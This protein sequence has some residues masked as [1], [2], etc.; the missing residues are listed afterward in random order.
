[1]FGGRGIEKKES[2]MA[3]ILRIATFLIIFIVGI[4]IIVMLRRLQIPARVRRAEELFGENEI[5]RASEI[6][7]LVL[8]KKKDYVPARYL[9]AK[10]LMAQKQFL[11]AIS[12]LNSILQMPDVKKF[13]S[14]SE[15]HYHLAD[16]YNQTQQ[17]QKEIEEYKIILTFNSGDVRANY[18]VGH[19]LYRNHKY[20]EVKEHL[21]IAM[22]GDPSLSDCLLPLGVSSYHIG[23]YDDAESFLLKALENNPNLAE[24][25]YYLGLIF[26]KKTDHETAIRMFENARRD[27]RF[28]LKSLH[29]LGEIYFENG[30]YDK[31][32]E[33]LEQGIG[34][35]KSDDEESLSFRY[36]LAESYEV[37]NRI[38][39]A[40]YHW[41][42]ISKK[43][44]DYRDVRIKMDD[45]HRIL[46]NENMKLVFSQS[47]DELQPLLVEIISS[48]NYNIISKNAETKDE[49][50]FKAF[51]IKRINEPPILV[52][53]NRTVKEITENQILEFHK[54]IIREKS[55]SGIY[56]TTSK[57]SLRAKS[58]ATTR[59]I[60]LLDSSYLHKVIEKIRAK[61]Q[62]K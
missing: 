24:A 57:F 56:I 47:L 4:G 52:Y 10:I 12:E 2:A 51:N 62:K 21:T 48:L 32:V 43:N 11:L 17:W 13:L 54:L 41:E 16:L 33:M 29:M 61:I 40:M 9:R 31:A 3:L 37:Q 19:A 49:Y 53:F 55:K 26:M 23:D 46:N 18:R 60:E 59:L 27:G 25:Q 28:L 36:R 30:V 34:R 38:N 39:E 15:I 7:K 35:L 50:Y 14:E 20:R 8:E 6:V 1:M 58:A 45:Y 5:L 44:P 42:L 22:D